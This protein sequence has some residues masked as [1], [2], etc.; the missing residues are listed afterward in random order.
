MAKVLLSYVN[1]FMDNLIPLNVSLL[2]ACLKQA[3]HKTRLFDTTF[4]R[5]RDKTG[6]EER[7]E[8]LQV[9]NANLEK[10]GVREKSNLIQDFRKTINDF[11]PDLI[12]L[13]VV[14][15]TY[16][17]A[18]KMLNSIKDYEIPK[19]MG[20]IFATVSPENAIKN[21]SL[22]MLCV[23]E[24][25]KAIV[26]LANKL[27]KGDD[28]SHIE[29]LWVKKKGK[30]IKNPIRPLINLDDLPEQDWEIY[31]KERLFKPM[32]GKAWISGPIELTRG[33]KFNCAF[34]ANESLHKLY[35]QHA[36]YT[37]EKDV[38]RF[39]QELQIKKQ[40]YG[41]EYLYLVA[42]NFLQMN[43]KRFSEFT[44][45]YE[46][47]KLPFWIESRPEAVKPGRITLLN[48]IGCEGFSIGVEHGNEEFRKKT[49]NRFVKNE[50]IVS[51]FQEAKKSG[52]RVCA[53]NIIGFPTETRN[54]VF[55]TIELNRKL[56]PDNII[57]NIFCPYQGTRLH[58]LSVEKGYIPE[59]F[60]SG[61]YRFD[62]GLDMPQ[63]RKEEVKGLQRT[64][65]LYVY[66]SKNREGNIKKAEKFDK[67]G[68]KI[69]NELSEEFREK[70]L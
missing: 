63:L 47:I 21:K 8:T 34:C 5:T 45:M 10:Y 6:D 32:G 2:S 30:I 56:K 4:Y 49:L 28:Y 69:F 22:D 38:G 19:I 46:E 1:S 53:N 12:G 57:T 13:S 16:H 52:I 64:F 39:M 26:D 15:S 33:C 3:G 55:E 36:T 31:E 23:G 54:L 50:R 27:E 68:N 65:P 11:N 67:E 62:A 43:N 51:A 44:E 41:L 48:K 9:K 59:G 7:V 61:D 18:S 24:G 70:F 66:F 35:K 42:E 17:I 25:E 58:D 60:I 20:G 29:N 40:E 14:E 37:R